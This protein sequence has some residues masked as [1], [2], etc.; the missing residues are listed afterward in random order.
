MTR[1]SWRMIAPSSDTEALMQGFE[2]VLRVGRL[3][4]SFDRP[5]GIC[6]GWAIDLFLGRVTRR[7]G[8]VDVA[9]LRR[10]QA[11]I[12]EYLTDR[13]WFLEIAQQ[14]LLTVWSDGM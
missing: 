9:V 10:D 3:M 2:E 8:D 5:W 7:H 4:E 13:G 11:A 6:G 1:H 12:Q 14:G